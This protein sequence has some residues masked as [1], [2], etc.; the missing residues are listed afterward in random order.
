MVIGILL[1]DED[2]RVRFAHD[3]IETLVRLNFLG[4]EL[5]PAEIELFV[6][7]DPRVW[8]AYADDAS[9]RVH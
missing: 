4:V 3:R 7:T 6:R 1:S 8:S 9:D 5:T 2:L